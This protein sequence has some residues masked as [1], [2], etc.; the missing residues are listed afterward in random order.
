MATSE[1]HNTDQ[2]PTWCRREHDPD[3]PV[4]DDH[5]TEPSWTPAVILERERTDTGLVLS[6]SPTELV[7]T[8]AQPIRSPE[9]WIQIEEA[10]G[11]RFRL[12]LSIESAERL[13][14]SLTEQLGHLAD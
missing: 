14:R 13:Q 7:I 11:G 9:P 3:T 8:V 12:E 4:R 6:L 5:S 2:C 1:P 10:E